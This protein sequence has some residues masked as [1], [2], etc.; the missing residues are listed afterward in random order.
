[1]EKIILVNYINISNIDYRDVSKFMQEI[2][3]NCSP[4][5]EDNIISYWIP[6][7]GETR[8]ECINPKLVSEDDFIQAKQVLDRNQ[9][10]VNGIIN[11]YKLT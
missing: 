10:I 2:I 4:K 7:N 6:I 1:M 9:D 3:I 5:D 11:E 8:I